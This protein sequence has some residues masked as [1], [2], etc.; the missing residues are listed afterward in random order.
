MTDILKWFFFFFGNKKNTGIHHPVLLDC[1]F[2][3]LQHVS[4][5]RQNIPCNL[6]SARPPQNLPC[7]RIWLHITPWPIHWKEHHWN[8]GCHFWDGLVLLFLHWG[9]QKETVIKRSSI[10][11][12][13]TYL[14]H[15]LLPLF[16]EFF[17]DLCAHPSIYKNSVIQY[18][19]FMIYRL[20]TKITHHFW[21]G[22]TWVIKTRKI[23]SLRN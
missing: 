3:E 11:L 20:K 14:L 13:G 15:I 21:L 10:G 16:L 12:S 2:C 6:S 22:K 19:I 5:Y 23:M 7:S 8:T 4:S 18:F 1:R 9:E 17:F